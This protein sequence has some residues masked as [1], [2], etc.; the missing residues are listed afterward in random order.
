MHAGERWGWRILVP[1]AIAS[2][3]LVALSVVVWLQWH[4]QVHQAGDRQTQDPQAMNWLDHDWL[5]SAE[6]WSR[7]NPVALEISRLPAKQASDI[8]IAVDVRNWSRKPVGW[9]TEFSAFL[10]WDVRTLDG[11]PVKPEFIS[12][13]QQTNESLSPA[14]GANGL[15]IQLEYSNV[16]RQKGA[17]HALFGFVHEYVLMYA[18]E[19]ASNEIVIEF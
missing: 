7:V 17:F 6:E 14:R 3:L 2:L 18:G 16:Y 13:V 1:I 15:R 10:S 5:A 12:K 8:R 4:P 9:D 19:A 11:K